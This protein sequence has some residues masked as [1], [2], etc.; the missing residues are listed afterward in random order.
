MPIL[1]ATQQEQRPRFFTGE[2][3]RIAFSPPSKSAAW[4]EGFMGGAE[5]FSKL[6]PPGTQ[7][8]EAKQLAEQI[9]QFEE[10][11]KYRYKALAQEMAIAR[12]NAAVRAAESGGDGMS[13]SEARFQFEVLA[14]PFRGAKVYYRTPVDY[15]ADLERHAD[16]LTQLMGRDQYDELVSEAREEAERWLLTGPLYGREREIGPAEYAK[17]YGKP[18]PGRWPWRKQRV[19][20]QRVWGQSWTPGTPS[21]IRELLRSL[22]Y[23]KLPPVRVMTPQELGVIMVNPQKQK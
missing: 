2:P 7:T 15:L 20:E 21:R 9:R 11:M 6:V 3:V 22:G 18:M 5:A 17:I 13:P 16:E 12:L 23:A 10:Q 8:L 19:F 1:D 4:L 14:A